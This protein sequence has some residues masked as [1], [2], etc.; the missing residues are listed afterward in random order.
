MKRLTL[1]IAVLLGL[2]LAVP[3]FGG[4]GIDLNGTHFNLNLIGVSNP[5]KADMTGGDGH[6]IFVALGTKDAGVTSNIWLLPAADFKVCDANGFDEAHDCSGALLGNKFGAVF[7]LPCDTHISTD[8]NCTDSP[9]ADRANYTVW[10]RALGKPVDSISTLTLCATNPTTLLQDCN[11]GGFV[12][13]LTAHSTKQFTNVTSQLTILHNVCFNDAD[14]GGPTCEN[15]ALF[16]DQFFDWVWQY[17]N[18]GLK[19][20]QL[21][22]YLVQ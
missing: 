1:S 16:D 20:I 6:T 18:K 4:N 19:L 7:E 13:P 10:F 12:V 2:A 3:A 9:A 22:F 15:V 8:E 21:R 11:T 14:A 5:K 17:D